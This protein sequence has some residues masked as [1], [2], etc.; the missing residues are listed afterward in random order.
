MK[1]EKMELV[2][3]CTTFTEVMAVVDDWMEYYND[4][5]YQ[6]NLEKLSLREYYRYRQSD[7]YP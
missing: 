1:E 6:W 4:D 7:A 2:T 3:Q 5:R